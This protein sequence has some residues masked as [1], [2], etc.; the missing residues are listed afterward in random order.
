V[1]L[2]NDSSPL[3]RECITEGLN[4]KVGSMSVQTDSNCQI[5]VSILANCTEPVGNTK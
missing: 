2:N 5:P 1:P 3:A 4:M